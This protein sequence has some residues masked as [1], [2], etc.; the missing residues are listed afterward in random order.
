MRFFR[1]VLCV[2][3]VRAPEVGMAPKYF[4]DSVECFVFVLSFARSKSPRDLIK[5]P[6][7]DL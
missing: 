5:R 1:V 6:C 4:H 3:A 7:P 2:E